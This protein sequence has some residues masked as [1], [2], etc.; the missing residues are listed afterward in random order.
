MLGD[1]GS[2]WEED[3]GDAYEGSS[4]GG[5]TVE[6][7]EAYAVVNSEVWVRIPPRP[8]KN[9]RNLEA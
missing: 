1:I 7:R 4:R 8:F 9:H 3:G 2:G 5:L 6:C